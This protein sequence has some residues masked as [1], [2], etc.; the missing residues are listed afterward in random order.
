YILKRVLSAIPMLFVVSVAI[1]S[2]I[3]LTPGNPASLLLG[4]DATSE[5]I[6]D[7]SKK[8]GL[9][10]PIYEQYLKWIGGAL[11][12]DLGESYFMGQSVMEAIKSHLGPTISL[13]IIAEI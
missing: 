10:E 13:A 12:G 1:F 2:I 11:Q 3:H 4:E 6:N 5:Q 8:M 9:N 7:L